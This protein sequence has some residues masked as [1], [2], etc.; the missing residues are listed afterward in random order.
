M[1]NKEKETKGKENNI[2]KWICI[3]MGLSLAGV[4][5]YNVVT[6]AAKFFTA[7]VTSVLSIGA[8]LLVSYYL[9]QVKNDKR[10]WIDNVEN[11]IDKIQ[12]EIHNTEAYEGPEKMCLLHQRSIN[13]KIEFLQSK[14]IS[15]ISNDLNYI[16][17]QFQTFRELY[18]EHMKDT[19]F[20]AGMEGDFH[21]II[22][23]ISD[24][25]DIMRIELRS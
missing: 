11:M 2:G 25:C 22:T 10:K 19:N 17:D 4:T 12:Q 18:S 3:V 7:N 5:I 9:T 14:K 20:P 16:H 1:Y 23:N 13:N 15:S 21:R 8:V 24:K 6:D